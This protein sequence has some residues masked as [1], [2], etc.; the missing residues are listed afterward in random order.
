MVQALSPLSRG[1]A[2]R[3][4]APTPSLHSGSPPLRR[5]GAEGLGGRS[6][7][8]WTAPGSRWWR[9]ALCPEGAQ[10][11]AGNRGFR[12]EQQRQVAPLRRRR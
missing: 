5:G 2:A 7:A 9:R 11:G 12:V 6:R 8:G 4:D 1:C 10:G 3:S